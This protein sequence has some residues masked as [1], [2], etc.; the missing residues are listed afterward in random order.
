MEYKVI[1]SRRKTAAIEVKNGQVTVRAPLYMTDGQIL[2]M[3]RRH[4]PQ[5]EE[6]LRRQKAAMAA[7][8]VR[9][10]TEED[11]RLLKEKAAQ[12]IPARVAYY[13]P[14]VGVRPASV[15]IR[16]Q[17]TRWGSC[18]NRGSLNFNCLLMLAPSQSIDS[19]V[20]HELCHLKH[21]DHSKA[22]YAEVRRVFPEYDKWNGWLKQ[23][24][25]RIMKAAFY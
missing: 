18:S 10:L 6:N 2:D 4:L 22:F 20:V 15:H 5:I 21:M 8:P 1:R 7:D 16:C 17:K 19:V 9:R 12:L 11:I 23:N 13:A 24:G 14:L 25:S 3:I